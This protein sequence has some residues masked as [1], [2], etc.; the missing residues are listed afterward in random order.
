MSPFNSPYLTQNY[1][2][3]YAE[4]SSDKT[5]LSN[6]VKSMTSLDVC[7]MKVYFSRRNR[8]QGIPSGLEIY[9]IWVECLVNKLSKITDVN[10]RFIRHIVT[11]INK[12]RETVTHYAGNHN[13]L[14]L[15]V[16]ELS[17]FDD[18]S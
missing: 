15:K 5:C 8:C 4:R 7:K 16:F 13:R 12:V 2:S 10:S 9:V 17:R 11:Q 14:C 6:S 18:K 1:H 3:N